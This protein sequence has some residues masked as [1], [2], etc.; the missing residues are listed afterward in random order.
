MEITLK[1]CASLESG[2]NFHILM[3]IAP[4]EFYGTILVTFG[5][6]LE[7]QGLLLGAGEPVVNLMYFGICPGGSQA[8]STGSVGGFASVPGV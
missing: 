1:T 4:R 7:A 8:E 5:V 3:K 6:I 2:I